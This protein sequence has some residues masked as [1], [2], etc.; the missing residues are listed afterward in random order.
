M[1]TDKTDVSLLVKDKVYSI[2]LPNKEIHDTTGIGDIFCSTFCCTMLK[3]KD[4]LWALCFAGGAAQAALDSKNVGLQKI[5]RKGQIQTN[6][7]YFYNL[8]KF[9]DL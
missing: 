6:A 8:V 7:S 5:P 1:L 2:T 4:F 3:E 9:R